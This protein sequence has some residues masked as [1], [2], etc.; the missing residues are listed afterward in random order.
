MVSVMGGA[1]SVVRI[2]VD[3]SICPSSRRR[4]QT[5][6]E[7]ICHASWKAGC[8]RT[9]P[10]GVLLL[11]FIG[12]QRLKGTTMQV[13]CHHVTGGEGVLRELGEKEFIDHA[14]AGVTDAA[15]F[16]GSRVGGHHDATAQALRP[17]RD[18]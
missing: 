9:P 10:V 13:K 4:F 14:L 18:I 3:S 16:L 8:M 12:K 2:G 11:V 6:C 7:T 1:N 5:H 17:H 15:L